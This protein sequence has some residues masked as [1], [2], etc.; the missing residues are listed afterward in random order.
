MAITLPGFSNNFND[1]TQPP[2]AVLMSRGYGTG[3]VTVALGQSENP[4]LP[5]PGGPTVGLAPL[6]VSA[7]LLSANSPQGSASIIT[8]LSAIS[9]GLLQ[10]NNTLTTVTL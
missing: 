6:A 7:Q 1:P 8:A 5:N 10:V 4:V 3:F 2:V 9:Q